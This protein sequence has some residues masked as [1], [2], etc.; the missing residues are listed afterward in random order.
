ML[1]GCGRFTE[2]DVRLVFP[3]PPAAAALRFGTPAWVLE[4]FEGGRV[5]R[6]FSPAGGASFSLGL[7]GAA[8]VPIT[9][10]MVFGPNAQDPG[11]AR[12]LFLPAGG[13]WPD[14]AGG[15]HSIRLSWEKGFPARLLVRLGRQ[16]YP[17]EAF[18]C[19]RFFYETLARAA[20]NPWALD[21]G[22]IIT[23]LSGLSFR[24]DKIKLL[25]AH[26]VSLSLPQGS[27]LPQSP[28]AGLVK[29]NAAGFAD[30]GP[31]A[32]GYHRYYKMEGPGF[33]GI[34]VQSGGLVL[35]TI[36]E[37]DFEGNS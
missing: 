17:V 20:G 12:E 5:R 25:P 8:A 26:A 33:A 31:L 30:F 27:W 36:S 15:G 23:T 24:A 28:L 14:D 1:A 10:Y 16:G 19:G 9:A 32:E 35:Y 34:Q 29:T 21:E 2:E 18:N 13:L 6:A 3:E 37:E 11:P 7:S 22:L 4:Y